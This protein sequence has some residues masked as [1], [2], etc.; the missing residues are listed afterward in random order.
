MPCLHSVCAWAPRLAP[1]L[2]SPPLTPGYQSRSVTTCG[3]TNGPICDEDWLRHDTAA[4]ETKFS[5]C[6]TLFQ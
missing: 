4:L 6:W 1:G 3:N 5:R 2:K